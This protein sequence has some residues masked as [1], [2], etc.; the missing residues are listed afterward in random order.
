MDS[1]PLDHP[2]LKKN[3]FDL[4]RLLFASMVCLVHAYDVSDFGQLAILAG[5]LSSKVA[6]QGFFV[7]SGFLIVMSYE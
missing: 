4:L 7:V 2:R 5:V 1:L 3:N 6:V